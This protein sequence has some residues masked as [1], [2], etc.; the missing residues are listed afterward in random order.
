MFLS[1]TGA[2]GLNQR[3]LF[4]DNFYWQAF[5]L[6][7]FL[8]IFPI[9]FLSECFDGSVITKKGIRW[10][11]LFLFFCLYCSGYLAATAR[12]QGTAHAAHQAMLS[13]RA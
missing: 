1:L 9:I 13:K 2:Q 12:P 11:L 3:D 7:T 10:D 4:Q 5:Y 8:T 6:S